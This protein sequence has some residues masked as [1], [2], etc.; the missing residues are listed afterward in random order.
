MSSRTTNEIRDE[1][2]RLMSEHIASLK[3]GR[4][5]G[6]TCDEVREHA[7]RLNRIRELSADY[8]SS[9]KKNVP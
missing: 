9:L 8:L 2:N 1:L 3:K 4:F 7:E 5:G 6:L